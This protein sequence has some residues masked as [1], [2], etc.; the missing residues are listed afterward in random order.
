MKAVYC[1]VMFLRGFSLQPQYSDEDVVGH[2]ESSAHAHHPRQTPTGLRQLHH[3]CYCVDKT[4]PNKQAE[5]E[6]SSEKLWYC[7]SVEQANHHKGNNVLQVILMASEDTKQSSFS[8]NRLM[9]HCFWNVWCMSKR[10]LDLRTRSTSSLTRSIFFFSSGVL[11]MW[12]SSVLANACIS[13]M[14]SCLAQTI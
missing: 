1:M 6:Q 5:V 14:R 8:H 9:F 3:I 13:W 7:Q 10:C 2:G 4:W 11:A 12:V